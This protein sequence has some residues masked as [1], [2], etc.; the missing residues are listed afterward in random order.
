MT[1]LK[2][3]SWDEIQ[4]LEAVAVGSVYD[5]S[6]FDGV[7]NKKISSVLKKIV[8][9]T[10][11]DIEYFKDQMKSHNIQVYHASPKELGYKDSILDYVDINGKI[12]YNSE[13]PE[14]VK[15]NLIPINPLQIRDDSIIMGNKLLITDKTFEVE[16]YAKKF[17]EW[18]GEDQIDLTIFN[19]DLK[20]HRSEYN[21][22]SAAID[23]G[24]PIDYYKQNHISTLA[25]F[26]SPNVTRV[27]KTCLVDLWQTPDAI[28]FLQS[29][30]PNFIYKD[31]CIGGHLDSIF[32][33]IKEGVIIA[34]P[35]FKEYEYI[36]PGWKI[37]Y[38]EDPNWTHVDKWA[39]LREKNRGS[40]WVPGE[41][42]ND[43]FTYFVESYLNNW[44]GNCEETI[45]DVNCLVVDDQNVVVNSDNPDLIKLLES[46]KLNPIVC[47]LRNR[48]FWDGGW[49]CI[50]LD[51]KRKGS[52]IDY[53]I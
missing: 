21:L 35:W 12:G 36:F 45:F 42:D 20:F 53:G 51:L 46:Y 52:Q 49:H 41:E 14:Y 6:F 15:K 40:W 28:N 34:A 23:Q 24:L 17:V 39:R 10:I 5:P 13:H 1:K 25:G 2:L 26:C 4:P 8:H 3:N 48:F 22:E 19:G 29:N 43:Q 11:E 37:T 7:K 50:T 18:F 44:T 33:V 32:S 27:G 16:G 31:L 9:E 38:F 47:P 30:Y